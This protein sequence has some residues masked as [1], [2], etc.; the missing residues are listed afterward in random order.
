MKRSVSAVLASAVL[1]GC[2]G[3]PVSAQ[4]AGQSADGIPYLET[5]KSDILTP[6]VTEIQSN[7]HPR[8]TFTIKVTVA[9]NGTAIMED[10]LLLTKGETVTFDCS[11]SPKDAD[12]DIGLMSSNGRFYYSNGSDGFFDGRVKIEN[13]GE[14]HLAIRNNSSFRSVVNGF[15]IY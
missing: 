8:T 12:L 4:G 2:L 15:L 13:S 1:I 9:A 11:Y 10:A 14:Y 3:L 7:I 6:P 5:W